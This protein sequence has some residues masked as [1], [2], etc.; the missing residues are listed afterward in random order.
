MGNPCEKYTKNRETENSY[1]ISEEGEEGIQKGARRREDKKKKISL[2]LQKS[3]G[4][5]V[6]RRY[7]VGD[8]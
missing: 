8:H 6:L 3:G 7:T 5:E 2:S 1:V 4:K